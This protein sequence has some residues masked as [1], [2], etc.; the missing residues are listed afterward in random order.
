MISEENLYAI[1]VQDFLNIWCW[2]GVLPAP[3]LDDEGYRVDGQT[4]PYE[5]T[6]WITEM[7]GFEVSVECIVCDDNSLEIV[8]NINENSQNIFSRRKLQ[9]TLG[10]FLLMEFDKLIKDAPMYC[11]HRAEY[12]PG[13]IPP[14]LFNVTPDPVESQAPTTAPVV[15]ENPP[16]PEISGTKSRSIIVTLCLGAGLALLWVLF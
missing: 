2:L 6:E 8:D 13:A 3:T 12:N 9:E 5:M 14:P 7:D 10:D 4:V 1:P 11:P 16:T 15:P